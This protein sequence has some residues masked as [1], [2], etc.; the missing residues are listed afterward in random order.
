M[1]SSAYLRLLIFLLAIFIRACASSSL[2]FC[3]MYSAYK[4]N[5]Q[6]D[7]TQPWHSP[8]PI[9]NQSVPC[10][11]NC[12]FLTCIQISQE[13][14]KVVWYSQL[15]KYF[16]QFVVVYTDKRFGIINKLDIFLEFSCFFYDPTDVCNFIS[17]SSAFSKTS[18]N[19]WKFTVHIVLK[20]GLEIPWESLIASRTSLAGPWIW[21][22][23]QALLSTLRILPLDFY[24]FPGFIKFDS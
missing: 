19:I 11:V 2:A 16:L 20:S 6:G 13:V 4:L 17:G 24:S 23:W 10:P 14:H 21:T 15:F 18:L 12:C 22:L 8:F 5:K 3:M 9:W 7:N 1:V